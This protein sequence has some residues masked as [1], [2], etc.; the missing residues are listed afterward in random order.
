M[1]PAQPTRTTIPCPRGAFPGS[2]MQQLMQMADP[3]MGQPDGP[4]GPRWGPHGLQ[5]PA[6]QAVA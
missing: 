2:E 6:L 5:G 4:D 1:A 3:W